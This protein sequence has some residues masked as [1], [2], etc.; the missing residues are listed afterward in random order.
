MR[1]SL[2]LDKKPLVSKGSGVG[3][4]T[5][6][7]PRASAPLRV[8]QFSAAVRSSR[9]PSIFLTFCLIPNGRESPPSPDTFSAGP[10][11]ADP[12]AA[13]GPALEEESEDESV[14]AGPTIT[15]EPPGAVAEVRSLLV[16]PP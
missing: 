11:L 13:A 6:G 1:L 2:S 8:N 4:A 12:S 10:E 14:A 7:R 3:R 15:A 5:T 9:Y 16:V